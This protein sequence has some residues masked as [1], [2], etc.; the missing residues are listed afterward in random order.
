MSCTNFEEGQLN[1][2]PYL[3][4]ISIKIAFASIIEFETLVSNAYIFFCYFQAVTFVL[5]GRKKGIRVNKYFQ[6]PA[7]QG[8][9]CRPL[10]RLCDKRTGRVN[11]EF[12]FLWLRMRFYY[13]LNHNNSSRSMVGE[14]RIP[15]SNSDN[16]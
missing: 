12:K 8:C 2:C 15:V 9:R 5:I 6:Q 1:N 3:T 7:V 10:L 16:Y 4:L 11:S 13:N 14:M